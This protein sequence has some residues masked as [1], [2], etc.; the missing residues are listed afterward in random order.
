MHATCLAHIILL[1]LN[2]MALLNYMSVLNYMLRQ[3]TSYH[4]VH[5]F[6]TRHC[7]DSAISFNC[8]TVMTEIIKNYYNL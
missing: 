7:T 6:Y 3:G 8:C 1:D 4:Q 5:Y 2:V